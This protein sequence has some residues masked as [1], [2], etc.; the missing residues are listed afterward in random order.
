[1]KFTVKSLLLLATVIALV[2]AVAVFS[3]RRGVKVEREA[4]K[5]RRDASTQEL[6]DSMLENPSDSVK[7]TIPDDVLKVLEELNLIDVR[8]LRAV[9]QPD[10]FPNYMVNG[11]N[12]YWIPEYKE[13]LR[14]LGWQAIW[15]R[16]DQ[17]Y[18]LAERK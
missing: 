14:R 17:E 4:A 7:L 10:D 18:S 2:I 3:F 13:R 15:S 5:A 9:E 12:N 1:M 16:R 8:E 11:R 6:I